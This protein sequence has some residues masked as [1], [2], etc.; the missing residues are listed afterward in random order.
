MHLTPQTILAPCH[1]Y[2]II[3]CNL[4]VLKSSWNAAQ[5]ADSPDDFNVGEDV[6]LSFPELVGIEPI[7]MDILE[8]RQK[9]FELKG[10]ARSYFS[11]ET[12]NFSNVAASIYFDLHVANYYEKGSSEPQ[13][14]VILE[15]ATERM[16]L[17]QTLAQRNN[18]AHLLMSSLEASKTYIDS[19]INSMA[20]ALIVTTASGLIKTINPSTQRLFGYCQ[21]EL[22]GQPISKL[23]KDER[24]SQ[25]INSSSGS[26][27]GE[28]FKDLEM[29]CQTKAGEEICIAFSASLIQ[30]DIEDLNNF[31]Y[32]G[33]DMTE[34][35]QT[36]IEMMK[37]LDRERELREL[38][39]NFISMASHEFRTPMT[40]ILSS[41]E[42]LEIYGNQWA[43][44]RKTKHFD[45]IKVSVERMTELLN[46][47]LL[48]SKIE[49]GK[50][51]FN[52]S[53]LNLREFCEDLTEEIQTGIGINHQ[54]KLRYSGSAPSAYMD[55]KLLL[56]ILSNLLANAVKYSP[57][58]TTVKLRCFCQET[59]VCF[60][61]Q[62]EG[63]G[64]PIEDQARLFESFHRAKNV[65]NIPGTGLGL[66]I[67]KNSVELHGGTITFISQVGIGTT[68][69]VTL[70]LNSSSSD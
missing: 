15:D 9:S 5:F 4:I 13:L 12:N 10:I 58:E 36:E 60:E 47:V 6:R 7:L 16:V 27:S 51:K 59:E 63:I 65:G 41:T 21:E 3:D 39:S 56:H 45:R 23:I 44:D 32:I 19:I 20:D 61:I 53:P 17:R 30:T 26:V 31:V 55:E 52:P 14:I 8:G 50:L 37:A 62:D 69:R 68:F 25:T 22:I 64:I 54:I 2:L 67:V 70:P 46:D 48:F 11:G 18:E 34:R 29:V 1:Q 43:Y 49:S 57:Q 42:L 28:I 40:S 35:K 24:F 66:S 33:R 38:K